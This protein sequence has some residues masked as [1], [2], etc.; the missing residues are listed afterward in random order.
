[1]RKPLA[2]PPDGRAAFLKRIPALPEVAECHH[3]SGDDDYLLKVRCRG[4]RDLDRLL[5]RVRTPGTV[6]SDSTIPTLEVE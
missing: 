4:T 2:T 6:L 1:M 3:V 5:V